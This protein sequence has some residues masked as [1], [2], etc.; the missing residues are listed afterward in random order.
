MTM[1]NQF[2]I[3]RHI[4]LSNQPK[5][6]GCVDRSILNKIALSIEPIQGKILNKRFDFRLT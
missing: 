3:N 1:E 4:P 6:E 5:N 2:G